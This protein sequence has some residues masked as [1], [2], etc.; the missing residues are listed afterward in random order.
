MTKDRRKLKTMGQMTQDQGLSPERPN[1]KKQ[2]TSDHKTTQPWRAVES[3]TVGLSSKQNRSTE[4][5]HNARRT[6]YK[7]TDQRA[8]VEADSATVRN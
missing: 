8:H 1:P 7:I 2:A 3:R 4:V 6:E 5:D